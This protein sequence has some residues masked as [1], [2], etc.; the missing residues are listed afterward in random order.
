MYPTVVILLVETQRSITEIC[1]IGPLN[2]ST[3]AGPVASEPRPATLGQ[4]SFAVW[5]V[6]S[7]TDKEAE[8]QRSRTLQSQGGQEYGLVEIILDENDSQVNTSGY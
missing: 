4:L 2:A 1:E 8:S 3:L 6:H 7:M 5:P